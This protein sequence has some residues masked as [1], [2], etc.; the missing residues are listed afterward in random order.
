M[1]SGAPDN[2]L[3]E[4]E[5][6]WLSSRGPGSIWNHLEVPVRSIRVTGSIACGFWTDLHFADAILV[7]YLVLIQWSN[8]HEVAWCIL[9]AGL[10]PNLCPGIIT[11]VPREL[12]AG[13]LKLPQADCVHVVAMNI[14]SEST[15]VVAPLNG[16]L[17]GQSFKNMPHTV[18]EG[19]PPLPEMRTTTLAVWPQ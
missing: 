5:S 12:L 6:T 14:F 19:C 1:L 17:V 4:S 13:G 16:H 15:G 3:S 18:A 10:L 9:P 11:T 7:D 2:T 8:G